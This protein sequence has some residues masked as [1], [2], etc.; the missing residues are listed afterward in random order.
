MK[1]FGDSQTLRFEIEWDGPPTGDAERRTQGKATLEVGSRYVWGGRDRGFDWT[2][3]ELLEFLSEAWR[4]LLWEETYPE[5]LL[6]RTPFLLEAEFERWRE[7][8]SSTAAATL[9]DEVVSFLEH[10]DLACALQGATA[11]PVRVLRMGQLCTVTTKDAHLELPLSS[12]LEILEDLGTEIARRLD[13]A[14]DPRSRCASQAWS[15]RASVDAD[16]LLEFGV[17][18][19]KSH[20]STLQAHLPQDT[21]QWA[22]DELFAAA[23]FAGSSL[24]VHAFDQLLA[25]INELPF[26]ATPE[27][28]LLSVEAGLRFTPRDQPFQ[29]GY[30]LARAMREE[31]SKKPAPRIDVEA[32]LRRLDVEVHDIDLDTPSLN[33]VAVFGP[34]H[35]PA[36]FVNTSGRHSKGT[37]GR[38]AT[39]AH[40]LCHL[41]VDRGGALPLAEVLGGKA[42]RRPEQR[43]NAFAAELLVPAS[44]A[45]RATR[46]A[47]PQTRKDWAKL[48]RRL[49]EKFGASQSVSAW[50]TLNGSDA[51]GRPIEPPAKGWLESMAR[52]A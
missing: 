33:A 9:H 28:E 4:F 44:E 27:L 14:E 40:E 3:I 26:R 30:D 11:N 18:L 39:L 23:R 20:W 10:H 34:R 49:S 1:H 43:A 52:N 36:V 35:G 19:P 15:D 48:V 22:G 32:I 24:H 2:W 47:N 41:L 50:Q 7:Y 8:L 31:L 13:G 21:S 37:R 25:K 46:E 5:G 12:V 29:E 42:P 16:F 45:A 51:D 38:R 17:Q 6:P